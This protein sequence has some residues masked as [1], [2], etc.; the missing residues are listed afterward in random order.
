MLMPNL[1]EWAMIA[2][3]SSAAAFVALVWL[4]PR[5]LFARFRLGQGPSPDRAVWLFDEID[6][7]DMTDSA[8]LLFDD[9]PQRPDWTQLSDWLSSQ[10]PGFPREQ[11][12]IREAVRIVV[13]AA[14]QSD[15]N[16]V[17]CEFLNGVI[18]VEVTETEEAETAEAGGSSMLTSQRREL[19]ALRI[20]VDKSPYPIWRISESGRTTWFNSAYG[21]LERR[22]ASGHRD[23]PLF[24]LPPEIKGEAGTRRVPVNSG[25]RDQTHWFDVS[26]VPDG[27]GS[28]C[29]A[30]D[31]DAVVEAENAQRQF[32]QT[33]AKTFAQ[34]SIGLA[35]FDRN[36][37]LALF[38]PALVDLTGL[39]AEF[40]SAR[41]NMLSFFDRL[42]DQNMMPE[43]KNYN[44]WRHQMADLVAAASDGRYHE[45][46]SLPSGSVYSVS[47]KP[48]PD[49]AIAFLFED[50]TA[51]ISLTRRFRSDLEM[52]QSILD[53]LDR[54]IAVFSSDGSLTITNAAYRTLW[55]V[56][57]EKSF[58]QMSVI[59]ATRTWQDQCKA[60]PIWSD[61][62]DFVATRENRT[63]WSAEIKLASG[64]PLICD[65]M[66]IQKGATMVSFTRGDQLTAIGG[67]KR[68][69]A[70]HT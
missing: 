35:I 53:R 27:T 56:D 16:C 70:A 6:L 1:T 12:T 38:N 34:L 20:T 60:S 14:E 29:Y 4:F 47:G 48:H 36:R 54:A 21:N 2:V 32:V 67:R 40:L 10:F 8:R 52:G 45:T 63:D 44:S 19:E 26:I 13:Q 30:V 61:I 68:T 58:A 55:S 3:T 42:R 22:T 62:R 5:T 33:L 59:D 15:S 69:A 11:A 28:L 31:I 39:S 46:W 17:V 23:D 57:P 51:E 50:I 37:Q 24:D 66:P 49:G 41:P 18:R 64:D 9:G 65:V 25:D 7:I 43:P